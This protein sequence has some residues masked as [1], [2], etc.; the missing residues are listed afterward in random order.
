MPNITSVVVVY[1]KIASLILLTTALTPYSEE[2]NEPRINS[3][4]FSLF[5]ALRNEILSARN[6]AD[7]EWAAKLLKEFNDGQSSKIRS[8]PPSR[9]CYFTPIQCDLRS[10]KNGIASLMKVSD[11]LPSIAIR[12]TSFKAQLFN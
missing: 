9:S 7:S 12:E 4:S 1:V 2:E 8:L 3:G 5:K 11:I 10:N 6:L